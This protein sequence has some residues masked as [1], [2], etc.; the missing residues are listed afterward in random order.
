[1]DN[2]R[3]A[4]ALA[5]YEADEPHVD[6]PSYEGSDYYPAITYDE[7]LMHSQSDHAGD[8]VKMPM[9]CMRCWAERILHK[10]EF[11]EDFINTELG[12]R[13]GE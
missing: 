1:M 8:C 2:K 11:I 3:I 7:I 9:T 5:S 6:L 4:E 12:K 10:A 13:E